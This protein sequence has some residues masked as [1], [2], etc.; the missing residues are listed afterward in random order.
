MRVNP[1]SVWIHC[2]DS[3]GTVLMTW[4][5]TAAANWWVNVRTEGEGDQPGPKRKVVEVLCPVVDE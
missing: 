5:K 1:N 3:P 4:V 2:I